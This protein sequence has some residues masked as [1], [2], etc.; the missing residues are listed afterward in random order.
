MANE[1]SD[2]SYFDVS[3]PDKFLFAHEQYLS[4][5]DELSTARYFKK[6]NTKEFYSGMIAGLRLATTM[7]RNFQHIQ[8]IDD[9]ITDASCAS[10]ILALQKHL[11]SQ[12][13]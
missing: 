13:H 7:I 9:A 10:S 6:D 11:E 8:D 3:V 1:N 2:S 4:V 5:F 12:K